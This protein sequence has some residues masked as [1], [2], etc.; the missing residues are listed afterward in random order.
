VWGIAHIK[1]KANLGE[2]ED[3]DLKVKDIDGNVVAIGV[4]IQS[5]KAGI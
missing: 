4:R 3:K 1:R 5:S 2:I